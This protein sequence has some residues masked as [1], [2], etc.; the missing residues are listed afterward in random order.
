MIKFSDD[1]HCHWTYRKGE[2]VSFLNYPTRELAEAAV[3]D[4]PG[5]EVIQAH[6]STCECSEGES[7]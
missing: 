4:L 7:E 5:V 6:V 3:G 1:S 2:Y